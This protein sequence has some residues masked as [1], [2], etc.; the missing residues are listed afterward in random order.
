MTDLSTVPSP[1]TPPP[2]PAAPAA[3]RPAPGGR[4]A[5]EVGPAD[6]DADRAADDG[7]DTGGEA[8]STT[9]TIRPWIDPL[10]DDNGHDPRSRYVETFWLGVLGPTATWLLRRLVAGLEQ[11]PEGYEMDLASTAEAMGL[12]YSTSRSSPFSKAV[13]RCSMFGLAHQT[14]DGMAVRRRV[15]TVAHRHLRRMPPSVQDAHEAWR[16]ATVTL[17]ELSRAHRLAVVMREDGD[18][19]ETIEHHLVALGIADAVA[20]DVVDNMRRL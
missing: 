17:D 10:V 7:T 9:V 16:Q 3:A 11:E 4:P 18:D 15:P 19:I 20:A 13:Q 2:G 14:S 5:V 12:S 8:A 6:R 1:S